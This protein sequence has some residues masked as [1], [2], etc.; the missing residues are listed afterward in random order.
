MAAAGVTA[1]AV[2]AY[3]PDLQHRVMSPRPSCLFRRITGLKCP[4]CG[5]THA[6]I[7]L[8]HGHLVSALQQNAIVF[9]LVL[10][11]AVVLANTWARGRS[12]V[13]WIS[14]KVPLVNVSRAAVLAGV[15]A[16][17]RDV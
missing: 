9:L 15:Y 1:G 8:G 17:V 5:M 6:V 16:V 11:A 2:L 7:A 14:S 3:I 12:A 10:A 4:F 13:G